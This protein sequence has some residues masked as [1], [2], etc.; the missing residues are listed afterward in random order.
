MEPQEQETAP[1]PAAQQP[2]AAEPE[3]VSV[4]EPDRARYADPEPLAEH[5]ARLPVP[6]RRGV[7]NGFGR[8]PVHN[9]S[10]V[11]ENGAYPAKAVEDETITVKANIFREGHDALGACIV[12]TDPAGAEQRFDMAQIEPMGL[13]IWAAQVP[14]GAPGDYSFRVEA[15]D[16]RWRTWRHNADIKF[17]AG[18]DIPLVCAEGSILLNEAAASARA[19][20]AE[21]DAAL[22][23]DTAQRLDAD[24]PVGRLTALV[25]DPAVNA[26]MGRWLPRRL[27][28]PT[29]EFPLVVHRRGAQFS[30]WYEFFPRSV[31]AVRHE[32]GSWTSGTFRSS[33]KMLERIAAL[34][35]TVA[36]LPPISPIGRAFRKGPNNTLQAGPNDP[37]SPW[38]IGSADG[39]HDAV[40]PELGTIE[41]FDHFVARAHELGLE[42]ALDFALQ[43]SPDHPW[44]VEHPEWFTT[45]ADGT[46]AYA[47]NPPKKYQ[48][49]YPINF[50]NDPEGIYN[51]AL[52]LAEFWIDHG[53]TILRVDNPHTKPVDFWAW[54]AARLHERH[55]EVVIQAE[56]FTRPEMMHALAKVGFHLSYCYYTWRNTKYELSE[57]LTEL[58]TQSVDFFRPNFFTN[59]PDINPRFTQSGNPAAFAIRMILAATMS[60]AWGVYSGFELCEHELLKPGGEEYLNSEKYEYRPRDYEAE[61]NLNGLMTMLNAIRAG[62]RALQQMRGTQVLATSSDKIFAFAKRDG[63][64]RVVTIVSLDPDQGVDGTVHIDLAWL[65]LAPD[66]RIRV[67][68]ELTGQ[69]FDWG[70]DNYVRLWPAQPAHILSV[71]PAD[72]G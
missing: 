41:D 13:D 59:T 72:Q 33:E 25:T 44:A 62:H 63:Q 30:S 19:A 12:L 11:L 42:I 43:A 61:P 2:V 9:V 3:H 51:E 69:D 54:F 24:A 17:E 10:P 45:R 7:P 58:S 46:I 34:G 21:Q 71:R 67:H 39:G 57:Y 16:D 36:Y 66:A 64:D 27:L 4:A 70:A 29:G 40:N 23:A 52:R 28:T 5:P 20:G 6:S 50:D 55:P 56:A 31:G 26:G 32:D 65:G 18:L 22:L 47:E 68:D 53:V 37:G 49:I 38:A 8:I 1:E 15:Y 14:L 60:P 35:F 48:D